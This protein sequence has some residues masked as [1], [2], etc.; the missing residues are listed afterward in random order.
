MKDLNQHID[1]ELAGK[2]LSNECTPE[3]VV[4]FESWL[5]ASD[6]NREEFESIRAIYEVDTTE[7]DIDVDAA[8]QA[9]S[10]QTTSDIKRLSSEISI[11]KRSIGFY[12]IAA[13]I[14][15][16][17]GISAALW[18]MRTDDLL[19]LQSGNKIAS[20]TL[21]DG[22]VVDLQEHTILSYPKTFDGTTREV[23]LSGDDALSGLAYFDVA[24]DKSKPFIIHTSGGDVT[25]VGTEFEVQTDMSDYDLRVTVNEGIV[26]VSNPRIENSERVTAGQ[27][28]EITFGGTEIRIEENTDV[29]PFFWKDKT[30]KFKRTQ[31]SNVVQ[32]L[33]TLLNMDIQLS[34]E[35]LAKCELTVTFTNETPE[36]IAEIIA[37]TLGLEVTRNGNAY[38]LSGTGCK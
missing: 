26:E 4:A 1:F 37:M 19:K 32:S 2:Y 7:Q 33:N 36:T 8:W 18:F 16:I 3:E 21:E 31:L 10:E 35:E 17:I 14:A 25:V 6:A 5:N 27:V 34:S 28:A 22:T 20:I 12:R 9:V 24:P 15:V 30:I 29:A 23:T 13:A 38:I 11:P